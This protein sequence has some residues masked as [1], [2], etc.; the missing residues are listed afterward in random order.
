M[1][2]K[3]T[4]KLNQDIIKLAKQFA[5]EHKKSLSKLVEHYFKYLIQDNKHIEYSPLIKEL[6]GIISLPDDFDTSKVYTEFLLKKHN[7]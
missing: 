2:T 1:N 7:L 3:L 6:S 4:L 5:K